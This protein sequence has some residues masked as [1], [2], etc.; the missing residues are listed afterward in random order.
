MQELVLLSCI[1]VN[2]DGIQITITNN[3]L[4][5]E[6]LNNG[7]GIHSSNEPGPIVAQD[8]FSGTDRQ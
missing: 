3:A 2:S 5:Y 1:K 7:I 4:M 8:L 6:F